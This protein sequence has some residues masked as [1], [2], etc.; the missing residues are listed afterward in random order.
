[1]YQLKEW[2]VVSPFN[3]YV[4]P[5]VQ[6]RRLSGIRVDTGK[7]IITSPI[8]GATGRV[9]TTRSGSRYELVGPSSDDYVAWC[10]ETGRT[11]DPE[12]PI[13]IK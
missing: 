3:P 11:I 5:E 9:I 13:A 1:M 2:G 12:Q 10:K 8:I 4:A 7:G 6:P